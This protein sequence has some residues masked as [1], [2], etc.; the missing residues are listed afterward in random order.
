MKTRIITFVVMFTLP[1]VLKGQ[2]NVN[3]DDAEKNLSALL[4]Y[5]FLGGKN[6]LS[7]LTPELFF[8]WNKYIL[9]KSGDLISEQIK[10]GPYASSQIEIKDSSSYLPA[11]MMP[12]NAGLIINNYWIV[13]THDFKLLLSPINLGLK[14]MS[15]FS[16]STN[17]LLQHNIRS[18]V[19]IQYSD[20]VS[21]TCQYSWGWHNLT[22][23]AESNF[24][25]TFGTRSTHIQ[26]ITITLQTKISKDTNGSPLYLFAAWRG[27]INGKEF[28][29]FQN[30]KILTFGLR[31][32]IDMT[33]VIQ[34][35]H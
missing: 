31:K 14:I 32:S 7:N 18:A 8:G 11:L 29:S 3:Q 34:A 24:T 10:V 6:S 23:V 2:T 33:T 22:S 35:A 28:S 20:L 13:E 25:N 1:F 5:N 16:D 4:S 9:G 27:F 26:Y 19:G 15:N 17:S 12:G 21:L 30:N